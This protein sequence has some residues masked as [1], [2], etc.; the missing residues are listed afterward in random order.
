MMRVEVSRPLPP[1]GVIDFDVAWHF[2]VPPYGGGRM[3]RIGARLYEIGQW[4]PRLVVY[5]DV[6]G[7]NPLPYIGAGEF[8]LEYGDFD[9][10]LTLPAGFVVAATGT[11]A[12]PLVVWGPTARARLARARRSAERVQIITKAEAEANTGKRTPGTKTWRFTAATCV[13]SPGPPPLTSAGT[14]RAGAAS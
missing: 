13:T 7:W 6:H 10:S 5:D 14:P 2:P 11:V 12:N 3:G 8:Y 1:R 9:V 4:Y